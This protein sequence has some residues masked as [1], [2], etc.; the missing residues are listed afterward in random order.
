MGKLTI[1]KGEKKFETFTK[2]TLNGLLFTFNTAED[3]GSDLYSQLHQFDLKISKTIDG[4]ITDKLVNLNLKELADYIFS[5]NEPLKEKTFEINRADGSG[6]DGVFRLP[7]YFG[8]NEVLKDGVG[9]YVEVTN[10]GFL[11]VDAALA[12]SIDVETIPSIGLKEFNWYLERIDLDQNKSD[13]DLNLGNDVFKVVYRPAEGTVNEV[14]NVEISSDK[15]NADFTKDI[16][17]NQLNNSYEPDTDYAQ[18]PIDLINYGITLNEVAL[19]LE[20][21]GSSVG[22]SIIVSRR[23]LTPQLLNNI[24]M[25]SA[26]HQTEN[27]LHVKKSVSTKCSC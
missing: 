14:H 18:T 25:K 7:F 13:I 21:D 10:R 2:E 8:T 5:N 20:L 17:Y 3:S 1:G 22:R 27:I 11:G 15:L 16:V 24:Q 23:I 19:S 12:V 4:K 9:M 26:E 6:A